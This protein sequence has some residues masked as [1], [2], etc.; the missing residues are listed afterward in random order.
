MK[1]G[2]CSSVRS[3]SSEKRLSSGLAVSD[4]EAGGGAD[5]HLFL[6]LMK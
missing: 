2:F 1:F 5:E 6:C 3:G 4:E